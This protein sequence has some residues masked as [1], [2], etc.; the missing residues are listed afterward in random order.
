MRSP[1]CARSRSESSG[2]DL[3]S[4]Q[5]VG[6]LGQ[7]LRQNP[8]ARPDLDDDV[9]RLRLDRLDDAH[10]RAAVAEEVLAP[11]FLRVTHTLMSADHPSLTLLM[12]RLY[13]DSRG[14][15]VGWWGS[16]Q[17]HREHRFSVSSV[18]L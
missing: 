13:F 14:P 4:D 7:L 6:Q 17:R 16:P 9:I 18:P 11:L 3:D 10:H 1:N 8:L 5:F 12:T 2:I 15:G